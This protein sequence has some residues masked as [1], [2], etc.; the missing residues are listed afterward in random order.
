MMLQAR[1]SDDALS[2][3]LRCGGEATLSS[4]SPHS[5]RRGLADIPASHWQFIEEETRAWFETDT[6][7]FVHANAYPECAL[8]DQPD[9][10]LYW[11]PFGEPARHESGKV[12][13]CGHTP[14][15]TGTP[16]NIGHAVCIDTWAHGKGWLTCLDVGS[17]RYWQANQRGESRESWL[18][19]G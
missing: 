1:E 17:G 4:Y 5:D 11:E 15:K 10:M 18:D 2:E 16:L 14:Q 13:V 12:M 3:W 9:F 7:F 6:H 8:V 19:E